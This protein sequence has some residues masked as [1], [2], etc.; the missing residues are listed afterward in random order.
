[1]VTTDAKISSAYDGI[2]DANDSL[3][4]RRTFH[5]CHNLEDKWLAAPGCTHCN[6]VPS[7]SSYRPIFREL[8]FPVQ[9]LTPHLVLKGKNKVTYSSRFCNATTLFQPDKRE[10][11]FLL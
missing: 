10:V 4:L 5:V 7:L 2:R 9:A 6:T 1:M 11:S 3:K 8:F